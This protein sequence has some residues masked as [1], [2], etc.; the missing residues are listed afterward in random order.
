[1][2]PL[3]EEVS[4]RIE[5]LYVECR[6]F[7]LRYARRSLGTFAAYAE[8]AV[9]ETF[10]IACK[11]QAALLSSPKPKGWLFRTLKYVI[12]N[13]YR[14][15]CPFVQF[16]TNSLLCVSAPGSVADTATDL[17]FLYDTLCGIPDF[18]LLV[19]FFLWGEPILEIALSLSVT[20]AACRVRICRAKK[21]AREA[22]AAAPF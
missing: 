3:G 7:L 5:R 1:M 13:L 8:D 18:R 22:Y 2:Q 11:K 4:L 20:V 14:K 10:W 17:V 12:C 9:Q 16:P 19:R 15:L 21:R 6:S